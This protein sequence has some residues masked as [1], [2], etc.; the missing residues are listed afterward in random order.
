MV[1]EVHNLP[2]LNR[3]LRNA[4]LSS[5]SE[6]RLRGERSRIVTNVVVEEGT[7]VREVDEGRNGPAEMASRAVATTWVE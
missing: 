2:R 1:I 4:D 3:A 6:G 5:A 7:K